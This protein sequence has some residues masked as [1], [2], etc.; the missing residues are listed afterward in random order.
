MTRRLAFLL[1]CITVACGHPQR[2][3]PLA[4]PTPNEALARFL[5]AVKAN[6]INRMGNLWGTEHGPAAG[7]MNPQ[8]M[9][10]RLS[11]LQRYLAHSGYRV[12]D[13]PIATQLSGSD[14]ENAPS[15]DRLRT[16]HVDL[17]QDQCHRV[18]QIDVVRTD[19]GGWLVW[20]VHLDTLRNPRSGCQQAPPGTRQ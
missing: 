14:T 12:V 5:D 10:Q 13:G 15:L 3:A 2:P 9:S 4:A 18:A 19:S 7:R 20:L 6:D 17:D 1:A 11:V 8:S 16:F